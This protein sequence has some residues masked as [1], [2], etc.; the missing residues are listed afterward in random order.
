LGLIEYLLIGKQLPPTPT[1]PALEQTEFDA[2]SIGRLRAVIGK[3]GRS[4]RLQSA[5]TGLTPTQTSVLFT[6]ARCGPMSMSEL[7]RIEGINPTMLSRVIALLVDDGFVHRTP[8][9]DDRRAARVQATTAGSR[10]RIATHRARTA[11]LRAHLD[12]LDVGELHTLHA[13]LPIL[14]L[15]AQDLKETRN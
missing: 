14:E 8:D 15:L 10:L 2:D 4:L 12:H 5:E 1:P 9:P 7:A 13:A 11:T 6:I 3:L